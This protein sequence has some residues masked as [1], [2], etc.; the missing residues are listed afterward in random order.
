MKHIYIL[1]LLII[2]VACSN[3]D[4]T[5]ENPPLGDFTIMTE[6]I[7]STSVEI[8]WTTPENSDNTNVVYSIYLDDTLQQENITGNEFLLEELAPMTDYLVEVK[9]IDGSSASNSSTTFTT[10]EIPSLLTTK[11][12]VEDYPSIYAKINY[13][14]DK[15]NE[16]I[17]TFMDNDSTQYS[18]YYDAQNLL[19]KH[20][21]G[22]IYQGAT[23]A[24]YYY[25]GTRVNKIDASYGFPDAL[26]EEEYEYYSDFSGYAYRRRF[27]DAADTFTQEDSQNFITKDAQNRLIEHRKINF[28]D[29]TEKT[30]F[31]EYSDDNLTKISDS[32]GNTWEIEYDSNKNLITYYSGYRGG[33]ALSVAA[34]I[35][36]ISNTDLYLDLVRIPDFFNYRN[37]N[38]PTK[39]TKN[40]NGLKTFVYEYNEFDYP[41]KLIYG[42]DS[43]Y[44]FEYTAL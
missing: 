15:Q 16:D 2:S 20:R 39:I 26:T 1:I 44:L 21:G 37:N 38:N 35:H 4:A 25:F 11:I 43:A 42:N 24:E 10:L 40:G 3:D 27:T 7:T 6:N 22:N 32:D 30:Y 8:N 9:A 29:N 14:T 31:F 36:S 33:H 5:Q 23:I 34:G 12:T 19:I 28:T 17:F 41:I 13:R 18:Y